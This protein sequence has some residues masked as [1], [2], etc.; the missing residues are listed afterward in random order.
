[1]ARNT[2][3]AS[4]T[5]QAA[6]RLLDQSDASWDKCREV[7][8]DRFWNGKSALKERGQD[9]KN[10]TR[11]RA[12]WNE[13]FIIF[14]FQCWFDHLNV[15]ESWATDRSI[16]GLWERDVVEAF[17]QPE[18]CEEYFEIEVSPL[19]QWLDAHIREPRV[20]VDFGWN[21]QLRL[22]AFI[23]SAA[24]MWYAQVAIPFRSILLACVGEPV[25]SEGDAWRL[26]LF[27]MAG[28]APDRDYL[29]WRPT[30]T[31][32]PD[33]H[34]PGSFGNLIFLKD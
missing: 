28:E 19:G 5:S 21:S 7:T 25:P 13:D 33:F 26:N 20:D 31:P 6:E 1:M 34:K 9:W 3:F 10:L 23:D 30:F 18:A 2:L 11:V 15:D 14:S 12:Q 4:R 27:R 24:A 8:I 22:K 29:A 16:F 17:I 32:Q